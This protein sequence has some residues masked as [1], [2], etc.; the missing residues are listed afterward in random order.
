MKKKL[1]ALVAAATLLCGLFSIAAC[2]D[3]KDDA[4]S[5]STPGTSQPSESTPGTSEVPTPEGYVVY[6]SDYI[7]FAY[8][9]TWEK[10][11]AGTMVTFSESNLGGSNIIVTYMPKSEIFETLT[12][13]SFETT[14]KPELE[15]AQ[16]TLSDIK[17]EHRSKGSQKITVVSY[18]ATMM[19]VV[20][21]TQTM[22]VTNSGDKTCQIVVTEMKPVEGLVN[23]V[24]NT[25]KTLK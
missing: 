17:I 1:L 13:E 5:E 14:I 10:T 21:M 11:D 18:K 4:Q 20:S 19:Q 2:N 12:L 15:D 23:N 24:Y 16:M 6:A 22:I 25:L 9:K 3:K 8:P 7:S